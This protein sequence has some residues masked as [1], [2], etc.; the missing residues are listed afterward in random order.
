MALTLA[1][2]NDLIEATDA[3]KVRTRYVNLAERLQRLVAAR[4]LLLARKQECYGHSWEWRYDQSTGT[5]AQYVGPFAEDNLARDDALTHGS[6]PI[7]RL[8]FNYMIDETEILINMHQPERIIDEQNNLEVKTHVDAYDTIE[9]NF[10]GAPVNVANTPIGLFAYVVKEGATSTVGLNGGNHTAFPSG[11]GGLSSTTYD[12]YKNWNF[13]YAAVTQADA[14]M[15]M[16]IAAEQAD[17]MPPYAYPALE[18]T[19]TEEVYTGMENWISL[20]NAATAQNQNVGPDIAYYDGRALFHGAPITRV[21]RLDEAYDAQ[22]P[23]VMLNW[24]DGQF[25][26]NP[27]MFFRRKGP[28]EIDQ[29]HT[30]FAVYYDVMYQLVF[31]SRRR[32]VVGVA[33]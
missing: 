15:K 21:P 4:Q 1:N 31:Q 8:T 29:M 16:R 26:Y 17:F 25:L 19:P 13:T 28:R 30:T 32:Q 33:A 14:I 11:V 22:K 23:I 9:A 18:N 12:Q 3:T 20:T 27:G 6:V 5:S 10:W 7:C 24:A 2:I